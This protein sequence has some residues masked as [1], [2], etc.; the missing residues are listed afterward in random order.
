[1]SIRGRPAAF[2]AINGGKSGLK[3]RVGPCRVDARALQRREHGH[4]ARAR[5]VD[6]RR[7]VG[8]DDRGRAHGAVGAA[9]ER[10][11]C[12]AR[13]GRLRRQ[14]RRRLAGDGV[15]DGDDTGHGA[16]ANGLVEGRRNGAEIADVACGRWHRFQAQAQAQ[17]QSQRDNDESEDAAHRALKTRAAAAHFAAAI[18]RRDIQMSIQRA[19]IRLRHRVL[20]RAAAALRFSG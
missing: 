12:A 13:D 11:H 3:W 15:H 6:A 18:I 14:L 7:R 16:N 5:R 2:T 19:S 8:G 17:A 1:M 10:A 4:R 9:D 20:W